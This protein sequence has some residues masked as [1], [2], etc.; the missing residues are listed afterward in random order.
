MGEPLQGGP[1]HGEQPQGEHPGQ[2]GE[3]VQLGEQL[4]GRQGPEQEV[5]QVQLGEQPEVEQGLGQGGEQVQLEEQPEVE[6]PQGGQLQGSS[7]LQSYAWP[8]SPLRVCS[9]ARG[10]AQPQ[11][12]SA[13][14]SEL[15]P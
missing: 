5:V 13:P 4:E 9:G 2:G 11:A 12:G 8:A 1:H 10:A 3:K 7:G 14:A 15:E 6:Q